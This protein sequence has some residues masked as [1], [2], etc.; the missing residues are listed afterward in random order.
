METPPNEVSNLFFVDVSGGLHA[1]KYSC[2]SLVSFLLLGVSPLS[3][4]KKIVK[5]I[6]LS[7]IY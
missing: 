3:L 7:E 5:V 1:L 4:P 2:N 6:N